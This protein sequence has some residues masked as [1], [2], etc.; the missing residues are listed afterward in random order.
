VPEGFTVT[1]VGAAG[2][3]VAQEVMAETQ[4]AILPARLVPYLDTLRWAFIAIA[5]AG[6]VVALCARMDDWRRGRR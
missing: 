5:L 6:I 1:A 2:I 4:G 3:E